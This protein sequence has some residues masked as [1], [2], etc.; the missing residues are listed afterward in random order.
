MPVDY[1]AHE[2]TITLP[3]EVILELNRAYEAKSTALSAVIAAH[4]GDEL[5]LAQA[6]SVL[7][8]AERELAKVYDQASGDLW[9]LGPAMIRAA[10]IA[11]KHFEEQAA[12]REGLSGGAE[13]RS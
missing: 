7:A 12:T 9:V 13:V 2:V 6:R 8:A 11:A 10:L 5:V 1:Q 3:A 4:D